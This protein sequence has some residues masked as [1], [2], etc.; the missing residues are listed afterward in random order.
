[1]WSDDWDPDK[2]REITRTSRYTSARDYV[3]YLDEVKQ[4]NGWALGYSQRI[5]ASEALLDD[6]ALSSGHI[7]A[8]KRGRTRP[9]A[10]IIKTLVHGRQQRVGHGTCEI[11]GAKH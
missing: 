4:Q 2:A 6:S 10:K 11:L 8:A 3:D 5:V 1:M 9:A 7:G